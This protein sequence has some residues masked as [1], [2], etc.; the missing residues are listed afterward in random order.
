MRRDL[1]WSQRSIQA[2]HAA[3]NVVFRERRRLDEH[4]WGE[5]GPNFVFYGVP[6]E[7]ELLEL[8]ALLGPH[9]VGFREPDMGHHLTA[10]A[11]LG[12]TLAGFDEFALL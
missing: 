7:P 12:E 6:G 10:V 4:S 11:Y 3:A 8:E 1:P 9:A 2:A 5:H